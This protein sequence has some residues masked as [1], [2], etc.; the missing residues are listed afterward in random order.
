[1]QCIFFLSNFEPILTPWAPATYG[2]G[3]RN[4][5]RGHSVVKYSFTWT[6][7]RNQDVTMKLNSELIFIKCHP[8]LGA[9]LANDGF[10]WL[11]VNLD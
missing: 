5:G 11:V 10:I 1:M 7:S 2:K 6:F 3:R 4:R 8:H 9:R